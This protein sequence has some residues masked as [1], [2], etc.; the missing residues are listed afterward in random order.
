MSV[1]NNFNDEPIVLETNRSIAIK[2]I[3]SWIKM[4]VIGAIVGVLLVV[5]VIQRDNVYG[6]SMYPTLVSGEIIFTEKVS[7]YFDHYK[8]GDIVILDGE[9]MPDYNREEYLVKRIIALPGETIRFQDGYVYIKKVGESEFYKLEEPYLTEGM[10]TYAGRQ[11]EV[12]LGENEYYCL[13][14]NRIVSNDSRNLGPFSSDRI[15]GI[16]VI[17]VYP[18]DHFGLL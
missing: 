8:R 14:D 10:M 6:D 7:T 17:G 4:I 11:S 3:L 9:D 16:A 1:N 5:F 2:E 12:T 13:G 15:K 18:F